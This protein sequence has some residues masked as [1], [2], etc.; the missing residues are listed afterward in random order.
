M[1][2]LKMLKF[3]EDLLKFSIEM[4]LIIIDVKTISQNMH[5]TKLVLSII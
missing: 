4:T 2:V 1:K 3:H 5:V